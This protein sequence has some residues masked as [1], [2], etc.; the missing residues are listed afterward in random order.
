MLGWMNERSFFDPNKS[1]RLHAFV[2]DARDVSGYSDPSTSDTNCLSRQTTEKV[3]LL[4][5]F[6]KSAFFSGNRRTLWTR[7]SRTVRRPYIEFYVSLMH[8]E[9]KNRGRSPCSLEIYEQFRNIAVRT[10]RDELIELF[11]ELFVYIV[12]FPAGTFDFW[13]LQFLHVAIYLIA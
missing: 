1:Y 4:P 8:D 2:R 12:F 9:W 6:F 7:E 10:S 13:N 11:P 5:G 3:L